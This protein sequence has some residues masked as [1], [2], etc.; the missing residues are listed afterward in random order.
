LILAACS[1][2]S[3]SS[4]S[5]DRQSPTPTLFAATPT[6]PAIAR[7]PQTPQLGAGTATPRTRAEAF[8]RRIA[9]TDADLPP[10]LDAQ[11]PS[12]RDAAMLGPLGSSAVLSYGTA[13]DQAIRQSDATPIRAVSHAG[14]A[15][16]DAD[17]ARQSFEELAASLR[18]AVEAVASAPAQEVAGSD[19]LDLGDQRVMWRAVGA[20]ERVTLGVAVRR[21]AA[22]FTLLVSGTG[23]TAE[24]LARDQ[25]RRLDQRLAAALAAG[26]WP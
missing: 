1:R 3:G 25:S 23:T 8:L 7:P 5:V 12:F 14:Y 20:E 13:F 11:P 19:R 2:S 15:F 22:A 24:T 6:P 18:G 4:R 9:P 21:G 17:G 10:G 16:V 26:L